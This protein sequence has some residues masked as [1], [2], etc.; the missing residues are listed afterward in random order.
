MLFRSPTH[1]HTPTHT[2]TQVDE[3]LR[4]A[5][6]DKQEHDTAVQ[7]ALTQAL[8][9]EAGS[10]RA[11]VARLAAVWA[12][13]AGA[14]QER[15]EGALAANTGGVGGGDVSLASLSLSMH[16]GPGVRVRVRVWGAGRVRGC[17]TS[18]RAWAIS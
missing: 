4:T 1:T 17:A 5:M 14:V 16:R 8:A 6:A 7:A 2:R 9:S 12:Q 3:A 15:L 13:A 11:D 18:L 10:P